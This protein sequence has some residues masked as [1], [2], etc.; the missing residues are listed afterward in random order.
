MNIPSELEHVLTSSSDTLSGAVRFRGTRVPIQ[1]LL[2]T[3]GTGGSVEDF[4]QGYPDVSRLQ[5]EAVL[6]WSANE[7]RVTFGLKRVS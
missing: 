3:V 6:K 2:D 4:L 5:V 1:A 7:A